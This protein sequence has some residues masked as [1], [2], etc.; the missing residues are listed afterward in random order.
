LC[1]YSHLVI[2]FGI[3][4]SSFLKS[5]D[6]EEAPLL[7]QTAFGKFCVNEKRER[8]GR[9]PAKKCTCMKKK[10]VKNHRCVNL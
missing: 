4:F 10:T 6:I 8:K 5:K 3:A 7:F 2:V 1:S 9:N